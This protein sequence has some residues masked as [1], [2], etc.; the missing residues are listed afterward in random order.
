VAGI[1]IGLVVGKPIGIVGATALGVRIGWCR[2]PPGVTWRD[3]VLMGCLAG[4]GFTMSIF[5]ATLAFRDPALLA[6]AKL[7][8]IAA[9]ALAG[10]TA[11]VLSR[12]LKK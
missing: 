12:T 1:V 2:L 7:A 11:L 4:I 8:V 9:S 3:I 6:A 5:I 10:L